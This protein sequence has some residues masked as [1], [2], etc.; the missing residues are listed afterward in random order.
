MFERWLVMTDLDGTLLNH[1]DYSYQ[2]AQPVLRMLAQNN[3]PVIFNSSKTYAELT[4]LSDRLNPDQPFIVEN[5]S[6][7]FIP[8]HYFD[9]AFRQK[10]L[11]DAQRIQGYLV[12]IEGKSLAELN[13]FIQR[14]KPAA[15]NFCNC[16]VEQAMEL[17]GLSRAEAVLAQ[18]RLFSVPLVFEGDEQE[19]DFKR[20]ATEAGLHCLKGG[21]FLHLLGQCDKGSSMQVLKKLYEAFSEQSFGVIALGDGQNDIDMLEQADI[22]VLVK[23][24]SSLQLAVQHTALIRTEQEAPAG[25]AEGVEAALHKIKSNT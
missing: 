18:K 19:A 6:A 22:A 4:T 11:P 1:H 21:R 9:T 16:S 2:A 25:W 5:G 14:E 3:I 7:I 12:F 17:T 20:R 8:E 10:Y 23:S 15:I 13:A 24:P